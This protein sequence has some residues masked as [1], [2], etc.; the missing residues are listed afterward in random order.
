[1]LFF[2]VSLFISLHAQQECPKLDSYF[3][4][5]NYTACSKYDIPDMSTRCKYLKAVCSM[6]ISDN[7][8]A[9]YAFSLIGAQVDKT[10]GFSEL[11]ALSLSSMVEVQFMNGEYSKARLLAQ[12]VNA[13]LARKLP[14]SYPYFVSELLLAKSYINS[15]DTVSAQKRLILAKTAGME[16]MLSDSIE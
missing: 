11:N 14:Y 5:G 15:F 7:D 16:T 2:L 13:L 3:I 4:L 8:T 10:K 6:A 1:M 12:E 9:R